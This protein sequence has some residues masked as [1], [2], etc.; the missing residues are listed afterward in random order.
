MSAAT[1]YTEALEIQCKLMLNIARRLDEKGYAVVVHQLNTD[2]A[3]NNF[4][5]SYL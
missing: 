2:A 3:H 1:T 5:Y 4:P